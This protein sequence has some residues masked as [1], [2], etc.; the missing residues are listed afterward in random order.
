MS[1]PDLADSKFVE[2]PLRSTSL[3]VQKDRR[4]ATINTPGTTFDRTK[5]T[6]QFKRIQEHS[7]LR[8]QER[9]QQI[10]DLDLELARVTAKLAHVTMQRQETYKTIM[11]EAVHVPLEQ[12]AERLS[13]KKETSAPSVRPQHEQWMKMESRLSN[14]EAQMIDNVQVSTANK[15][16]EQF[17]QIKQSLQ[18]LVVPLPEQQQEMKQSRM[19][20]AQMDQVAGTFKRYLFEERSARM[21]AVE[22]STETIKN[23]QDLDEKRGQ[24]YLLQIQELRRS[25]ARER[26]ERQRQDDGTQQQIHQ[27]SRLLQV[28][29][30]SS[31]DDEHENNELLL[32]LTES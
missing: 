26:L 13:F 5:H 7:I 28:A 32:R 15:E 1:S 22:L 23:R 12:M 16:K 30:L 8:R 17:A 21:A 9:L 11:T 10:H 3:F 29:V 25:L 18:H 20:D 6:D 19:L 2:T 24:E 31:V 14:M 4:N 27:A